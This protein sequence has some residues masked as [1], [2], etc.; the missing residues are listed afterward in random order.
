MFMKIY[1]YKKFMY[2]YYY[3]KYQKFVSR[4][5]IEILYCII[6]HYIDYISYIKEFSVLQ[7]S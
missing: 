5:T 2:Y 4:L 1:V 6:F 7:K 3:I